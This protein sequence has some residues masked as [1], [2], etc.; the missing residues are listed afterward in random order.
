[1]KR[2]KAIEFIRFS[3]LGGVGVSI[4]YL[5]L[6]TLT[7]LKV[8]YLLSSVIAYIL[9]VFIS[10]LIHKF[11]TFKK[12]DKEV[13]AKQI[14]LYFIVAILFFATNTGLL[15]VLVE[16]CCINYLVAQIIL[17]VAL[18]V[19]NYFGTKTVFK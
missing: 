1:L 3:I 12:K 2:K 18:S 13:T 15:Y 11:H 17:T 5:I 8:W 4:G 7:E 14:A 6:Y 16:H 19:P 9:S 10:F